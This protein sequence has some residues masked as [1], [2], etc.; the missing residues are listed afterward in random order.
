MGPYEYVWEDLPE[1]QSAIVENLAGGQYSVT[2]T[3]GSGCEVTLE[4]SVGYRG[5]EVDFESFAAFCG[6]NG[7][8]ELIPANGE[9]PFTYEWS[10]D[11]E[12]NSATAT[13]LLP[14][15]Y[16]VTVTD[17]NDCKGTIDVEVE[18]IDE[19]PVD[20]HTTD[21]FCGFASGTIHLHH[22]QG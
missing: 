12:L 15:I 6:V 4:V 3:D 7:S 16:T 13:G 9:G 22:Y 17:S 18:S 2:I 20:I 11:T 21:S 19:L 10:H 1:N 8:I 5:L 14:G